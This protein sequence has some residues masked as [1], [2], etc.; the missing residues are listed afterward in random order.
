MTRR[1]LPAVVIEVWVDTLVVDASWPRRGRDELETGLRDALQEE[2]LDQAVAGQ[3][4]PGGAFTARM[5]DELRVAC[6]QV[7][8]GPDGAADWGN[9]AGRAIGADVG[10]RLWGTAMPGQRKDGR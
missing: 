3:R 4:R 8:S 7:A 9:A 2:L 5:F 1:P 6:S 10:G